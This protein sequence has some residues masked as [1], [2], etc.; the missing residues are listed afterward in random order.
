MRLSCKASVEMVKTSLSGRRIDRCGYEQQ[1]SIKA[2]EFHV[3]L[4]VA[5]LGLTA[6][7]DAFV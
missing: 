5:F 4:K 2:G 6:G 1:N 3:L 7:V